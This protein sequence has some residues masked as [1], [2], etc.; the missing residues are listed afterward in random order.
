MKTRAAF[1]RCFVRR[2]RDFSRAGSVFWGPHGGRTATT[3]LFAGG[4]TRDAYWPARSSQFVSTCA[5]AVPVAVRSRSAEVCAAIRSR[6]RL[7]VR[8]VE[9]CFPCLARSELIGPLGRP[10][11]GCALGVGAEVFGR[12]RGRLGW[13]R[14]RAAEQVQPALHTCSFH[15]K[16][17]FRPF[18]AFRA[19]RSP[20]HCGD[21][22][23][24]TISDKSGMSWP[25]SDAL[26]RP[27]LAEV[28]IGDLSLRTT[29]DL[30]N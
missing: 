11:E 16:P 19:G 3:G 15:G 28:A 6:C 14:R 13:R 20:A 30:G 1:L 2:F 4:R 24:F 10:I 8:Q 9:W 18:P 7:A 29:F 27:V 25:N 5:R 17:L 26:N 21:F 12:R 22:E 23:L